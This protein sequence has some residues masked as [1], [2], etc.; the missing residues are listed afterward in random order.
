VGWAPPARLEGSIRAKDLKDARAVR[1]GM[2]WDGM[3]E[4]CDVTGSGKTGNLVSGCCWEECEF[5]TELFIGITQLSLRS[6]AW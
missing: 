2:G 4:V 5:A 6:G 1:D 3:G